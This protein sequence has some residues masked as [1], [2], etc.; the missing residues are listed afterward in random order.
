MYEI[1]DIACNFTN[2]RFDNDLDT[3]INKAIENKK[4]TNLIDSYLAKTDFNGRIGIHFSKILYA[5]FF[6]SEKGD[7]FV[8]LRTFNPFSPRFLRRHF[9]SFGCPLIRFTN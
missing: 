9:N 3:V 8:W 1:S 7:R 2:D 5:F 4:K 6:K